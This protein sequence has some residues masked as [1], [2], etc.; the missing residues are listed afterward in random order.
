MAPT[1]MGAEKGLSPSVRIHHQYSQVHP[2]RRLQ[3]ACPAGTQRD[4]KIFSE[5]DERLQMVH[6]AVWP[7]E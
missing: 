7:K 4:P 1:K 3:E 2:Q 6:Q 5:G